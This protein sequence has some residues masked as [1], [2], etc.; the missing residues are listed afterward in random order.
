MDCEKLKFPV[1]AHHRIIVMA[2][3]RDHA[4]MVRLFSDFALVEPV[5]ESRASSG[6]RYVSYGLSVRLADRSEMDRFD[7]RLKLV[8][9]LK[10]VL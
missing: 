3:K 7:E 5:A 9:G 8:P 2:D 10:M 6:G 1:V 4:A